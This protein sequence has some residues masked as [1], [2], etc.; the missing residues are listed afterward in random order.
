MITLACFVVTVCALMT[1][2]VLH[3]CA[4]DMLEIGTYS[5]IRITFR[6]VVTSVWYPPTEFYWLY[7]QARQRHSSGGYELDSNRGNLGSVLGQ[8]M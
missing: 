8:F 3:K 1:T 2:I 5:Y 4:L 7:N 6:A